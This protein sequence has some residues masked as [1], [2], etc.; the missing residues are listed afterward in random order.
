MGRLCHGQNGNLQNADIGALG[1]ASVDKDETDD[2]PTGDPSEGALQFTRATDTS[3]TWTFDASLWDDWDRLFLGFHFG[4]SGNNP[5]DNP[6]SFVVELSPFDFTGTYAL[7]GGQLNGLSNIHLLGIRCTEPGCNEQ[8]VP[9]PATLLLIS[10][11]LLGLAATRR[12]WKQ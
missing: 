11:G 10:I 1:L 12:R 4:G 7:G 9:E 3:G 6:D 8:Q 5:E 2:F